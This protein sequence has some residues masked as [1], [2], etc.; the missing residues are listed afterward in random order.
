MPPPPPAPGQQ[1]PLGGQFQQGPAGYQYYAPAVG[2]QPHNDGMAIG[3]LVTGLV[4][5]PLA[6]FCGLLGAIP[7]GLGIGSVV[8]INKDPSLTGKG[9]AI[10]GIVLGG[11][12]LALMV[13]FVIIFAVGSANDPTFGT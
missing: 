6:L 2:A 1:P 7:V 13:L 8:R 5:V 9:M 10:A 12:S 3:A 4:S 11:I